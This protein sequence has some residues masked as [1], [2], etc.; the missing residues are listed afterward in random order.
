V[1]EQGFCSTEAS[2][3]TDSDERWKELCAPVAVEYDPT[4]FWAL[5]KE[6]YRLLEEKEPKAK[7]N[8]DAPRPAYN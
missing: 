4:K 1:H 7:S 3:E 5:S 8:N 6:I 2:V